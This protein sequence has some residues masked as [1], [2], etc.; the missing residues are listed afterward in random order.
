MPH[1]VAAPLLKLVE[2]KANL[3]EFRARWRAWRRSR[4]TSLRALLDERLTRVDFLHTPAG[5]L[6]E[7]IAGGSTLDLLEKPIET[8]HE[9]AARMLD[10]SSTA[11]PPKTRSGGSRISS[12]A[13]CGWTRSSRW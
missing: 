5:K 4:P 1:R 13:N 3:A 7:A 11:A 6:L 10:V 12:S 9:V 8:V 2:Q